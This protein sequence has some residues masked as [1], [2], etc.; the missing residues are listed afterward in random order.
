MECPKCHKTISDDAVICPHCHK[1]LSLVCPN[2][3]TLGHEAV[4][5][6]C[7]YIIL[8]KCAK[9]G[10][11]ISTTSKKCKCG[12]PTLL[13]VAYNECETDD[14]ASLEIKF[15][16]L[17][18]IR[19]ILAS[20]ELYNKFCIKL[21]NL[22][23]TQ[24]KNAGGNTIIYGDTYVVNFNKELS[25]S[26]SANKATRLAVKVANT[27]AFLN[28]KVIEELGIPLNLTLT[29][30]KKTSEELLS[31]K[32]IELKV[33][34]L[35]VNKAEKKYI[36]GM[37]IIIDENVNDAISKEYKT[38]TYYSS[39]QD[40]RSVML[41]E[42]LLDK[43]VLKPN[44]R[45]DSAD[46]AEI[47]PKQELIK[48]DKVLENKKNNLLN[49]KVLDINAKCKFEEATA[50]NLLDKLDSN[51]IISIRGDYDLGV[52]TSDIINFY[53]LKG[54]KVLNV[55]C[56]EELNFKPWGICGGIFREYF[57]ITDYS[58]ILPKNIDIKAFQNLFNLTREIPQKASTP[59]D[60]R[61]AYID[62]FIRFFNSL[63]NTVII[64]D[65]FE[66]IDDTSVQLFELYFDKFNNI[67]P[68]F[69]FITN[70]ETSLHS[71]IKG[72]LRTNL[73]TEIRL[74]PV[75]IETMLTN[76]KVDASDFI[77]SFYFEKIRENYNGSRLYFDNALKLLNTK[78][79]VVLFENK[80]LIRNNASVI[81]A[82]SLDGIFKSRLKILSKNSDAS[83]I[84]AY[85]ALIGT[86][87][88]F[89]T[90]EILGVNDI[91]KN[92]EI[93]E[94]EGFI[95]TKN[96]LIYLNNYNLVKPVILDALKK[97]AEQYLVKNILAKLGKQ[98]DTSTT[99]LL[100]G[101]IELFK[102]EY[103]LLWKN[104][105][106]AMD[107][108]DFDSYLKNCFGFL[109]LVEH[110]SDNI[111]EEEVENNK[112]EVYQNIIMS[113]YSYSPEKIYSI[114]QILLIDAINRDDNEQIL[115]LSN[116][117][118]QGA[119]ISSNYTDAMKLLHNILTKMENPVLLVDGAINTK[120]LLLSLINIEI[121]FNVGDYSGCIETAEELLEV[122]KPSVIEK[123]KPAS[124]SLNLFINHIME[125]FRLVGFAKVITLDSSLENFYDSVKNAL[126]EDLI[127]KD[128]LMA[129]RDY[130]AG[131]TPDIPKTQ[132]M[133]PF[134]KII[135]LILQEF[136]DNINNY[137]VFAQNIYQAKLLSAD[138]HQTIIER[139]CDLLIAR[140][141]AMLDVKQKAEA[142]YTDVIEK[143]EQLAMFN[144]YILAKYFMAKLKISKGEVEGAM[145]II[146]DSLAMIQKN[147]NSAKLME[148][149]FEKLLINTVKEKQFKFIDLEAEE[150]KLAQIAQNNELA[151]LT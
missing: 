23:T 113:L 145:L 115:K 20:K 122:I 53:K 81:I 102:E 3:K 41:Y 87:L 93:L 32:S 64:I 34:M 95:Y 118:L 106:F 66:N 138:L 48:N 56:T 112:K 29:I 149:L 150:Q 58:K 79:V 12:F 121:Q 33:K 139:F 43:Y 44:S 50:E 49:I 37:Q 35:N 114:E 21:K 69:V 18:A 22:L 46:G 92:I 110:I 103:L 54:M 55:T 105:K 146:N 96:D 84:L 19:R 68:N 135:Y 4:C 36:K 101:K 124:F 99:L 10:K 133:S 14:F 67:R 91:D 5:S 143:S 116:L 57:G 11:T 71:K 123:I 80:L 94:K 147:N 111:S 72:L 25:F 88:S 134:S 141:Y 90:L 27:F 125:T 120:F 140:S 131:K 17:K 60:A 85:F 117:M 119:L 45:E 77:K 38:D 26:T 15:G 144:V 89:S 75:K 104:S 65:G 107:L 42:L 47:I 76:I 132:E 151:R 39:E 30:L 59:E 16:S 148:F 8:E 31:K 62:E 2:C 52:K 137:K 6:N 108:G 129:I 13:S 142:I 61:F 28:Q 97:E 73:Y 136:S 24:I 126:G 86:K 78:E 9:C 40:G 51:K 98:L 82:S 128:A 83:M 74:L 63:K 1:V 127:D 7:G 130:L 109:S 70:D 100:M